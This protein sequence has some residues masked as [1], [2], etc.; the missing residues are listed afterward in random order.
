[1][2]AKVLVSPGAATFKSTMTSLEEW[3]LL[4]TIVTKS[5]YLA[6]RR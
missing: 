2:K 5:S 4:P 3:G 6:R 1:M